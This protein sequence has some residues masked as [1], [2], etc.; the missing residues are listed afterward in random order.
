MK[1]TKIFLTLQYVCL[2][3]TTAIPLIIA[4]IVSNDVKSGMP[5][6]AKVFLL[7]A[8]ILVII[9]TLVVEIVCVKKAS[10]ALNAEKSDEAVKT[11]KMMKIISVPFYVS[12]FII[13]IISA[14]LYFPLSLIT[15]PLD[16]LFCWIMI[17]ISGVL[18]IKAITKLKGDGKKI[19][20]I[21]SVLQV[22][23]VADVVSTLIINKKKK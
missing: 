12:N 10:N 1:L 22:L 23:P 3:A 2:A 20:P 16:F 7:T 6:L 11:W 17:I 8:A 5:A 15:I 14:P 9:A 18:G 13:Y 19:S 21:H 4:S